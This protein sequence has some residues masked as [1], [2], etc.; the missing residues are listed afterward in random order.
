MRFLAKINRGYVVR[1]V[2]FD[3]PHG[4]AAR[5]IAERMCEPGEHVEPR[6]SAVMLSSRRTVD[7]TP[8][9][10]WASRSPPRM[11]LSGIMAASSPITPATTEP[12]P[13]QSKRRANPSL[14]A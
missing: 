12:S 5:A 8:S 9:T 14:T 2:E 10:T 13:P 4:A 3:A 7:P 1:T 6:E 11:P